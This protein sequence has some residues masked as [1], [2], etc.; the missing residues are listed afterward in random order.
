MNEG[1]KLSFRNRR[2]FE[3][4]GHCRAAR[5]RPSRKSESAMLYQLYEAQRA[6][7]APFA[8]FAAATAKLYKHPLSPFTHT[9]G[10]QRL[11]AGFELLH[12][13]GMD[14]EKPEFEI[15]TVN[16][17]GVDVAVQEQI[18]LEKPFCR[19]IRFKRFSDDS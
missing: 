5:K 4:R 12:R 15:R 7:M 17:G 10:A 19:L 11:S 3:P 16:S 6:L 9:P 2:E 13:L 1:D 14:Y 8:D 18:A